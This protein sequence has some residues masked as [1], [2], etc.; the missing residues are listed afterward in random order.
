MQKF[1]KCFIN[2]NMICIM[3]IILIIDRILVLLLNLNTL[4]TFNSWETLCF[5][6]KCKFLGFSIS[7]DILNR[8]I[9]SSINTINR[10]C[11]D[12]RLDFSISNS[13]IK[14]K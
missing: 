2:I 3:T 1:K 11:N 12:V 4:H 14:S 13:E 8:D 10:K 9:Q 6:D 7:R 5:V